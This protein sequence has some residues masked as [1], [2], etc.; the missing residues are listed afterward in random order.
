[1]G[2]PGGNIAP[3]EAVGSAILAAGS[4]PINTVADPLMMTSAPHESLNRAAG[5]PAISTVGAPGGMI[6]VGTPEVAGLLIISVTLAAGSIR[7][8]SNV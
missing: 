3:P 8:I 7:L 6:G 5:S 2:A 1:V 4:P